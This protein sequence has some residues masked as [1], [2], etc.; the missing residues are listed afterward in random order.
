[1]AIRQALVNNLPH[2]RVRM[3]NLLSQAAGKKEHGL[4]F[5]P[6]SFREM[7]LRIS[8]RPGV[9]R[10]EPKNGGARQF[11]KGSLFSSHWHIHLPIVPSSIGL[12]EKIRRSLKSPSRMEMIDTRTS[13]SYIIVSRHRRLEIMLLAQKPSIERI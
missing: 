12:P 8:V 6:T 13:L 4:S 10:V 11:G 5:C 7:K 2:T 9:L 3:T 1:M